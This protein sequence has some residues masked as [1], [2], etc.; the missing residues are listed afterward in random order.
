MRGPSQNILYDKKQ[1]LSIYC[2]EKGE[3]PKK[4]TIYSVIE[5]IST[6]NIKIKLDKEKSG[7]ALG[8]NI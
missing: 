4:N 8:K 3:K 2:V 6:K 7:Y 5:Y 1:C